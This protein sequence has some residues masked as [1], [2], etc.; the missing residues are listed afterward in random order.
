MKIKVAVSAGILAI[1]M[2]SSF[3]SCGGTLDKPFIVDSPDSLLKVGTGKNG[4]GLDKHYKQTA[5]ID[6]TGQAWTP[7]GIYEESRYDRETTRKPFT[8]SFDGN[9]YAITELTIEGYSDSQ[10]MF[11]YLGTEGMVKNIAL[12][13]GSVSGSGYVGGLVGYNEGTVQ[14]CYSTGDVTGVHMYAG[15]LVGYN[16]GRVRNCYTTGNIGEGRFV[17]GVVGYNIVKYNKGIVQNCYASGRISG[18][19]DSVGGV[20]GRNSEGG[21]VSGCVGLNPSITRTRYSDNPIN[22]FG[23]V[24]GHNGRDG[25]HSYNYGRRRMRLPTPIYEPVKNDADGIHGAD[26]TSA[27]WNNADW[28]QKTAKFSSGAWNF[29][30][31]L[32]TLKGIGGNQN[33]AVR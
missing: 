11:G 16:T 3:A 33:P 23:R 4:W 9:G 1:I 13:G 28:W 18:Y 29:R 26:I 7:I 30:N 5:D 25:Y 19:S 20:V 21:K 14:N 2:T 24:V 22:S 15:G 6:M 8:G 32:P 17:G 12:V 10:G 27:Q 31:G